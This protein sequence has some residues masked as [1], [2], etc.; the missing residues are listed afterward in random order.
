MKKIAPK[1]GCPAGRAFDYAG[2]SWIGLEDHDGGRPAR[3]SSRP[4]PLTRQ[5][6]TSPSPAE[7]NTFNGAYLDNL[8][9][10]AKW[11]QTPS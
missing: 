6:T 2:Q 3:T 1:Y 7:R 5:L 10:D 9:E 11:P 4:E 8:L